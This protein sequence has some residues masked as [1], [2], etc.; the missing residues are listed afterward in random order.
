LYLARFIVVEAPPNSLPLVIESFLT[1][2]GS[3]IARQLQ[4]RLCELPFVDTVGILIGWREVRKQFRCLAAEIQL[5]LFVIDQTEQGLMMPV[6]FPQ[7]LGR[8][9]TPSGHETHP[10]LDARRYLERELRGL[11]DGNKGIQG[12]LL[13]GWWHRSEHR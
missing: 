7:G 9:K 13:I 2:V 12:R 3:D 10:L 4:E 5:Y 11:D 6:S 8:G 1:F